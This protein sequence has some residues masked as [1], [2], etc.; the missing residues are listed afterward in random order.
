MLCT[1][2]QS[3]SRLAEPKRQT[4]QVQCPRP[5]PLQPLA[6]SFPLLVSVMDYSSFCFFF[7]MFLAVINS[8]DRNP[9]SALMSSSFRGTPVPIAHS[10][11]LDPIPTSL[12]LPGWTPP[13]PSLRLWSCPHPDPPVLSLLC[14]SR[15]VLQV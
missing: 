14:P 2:P 12:Y 11:T 3:S 15:D 8:Y 13:I 6:T 5:L 4:H 1:H 9:P 10:S 7:L